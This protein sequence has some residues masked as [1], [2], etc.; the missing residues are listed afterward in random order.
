MLDEIS[1]G[2]AAMSDALA[3]WFVFLLCR[4]IP[5]D[6]IGLNSAFLTRARAAACGLF[7]DSTQILRGQP[8]LHRVTLATLPTSNFQ[9]LTVALSMRARAI[10]FLYSLFPLFPLLFSRAIRNTC[11]C[12][13]VDN[14]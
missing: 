7:Q 4:S 12:G 6:P 8:M 13:A 14:S 9:H 5:H 1:D 2:M 10:T 11:V 3:E